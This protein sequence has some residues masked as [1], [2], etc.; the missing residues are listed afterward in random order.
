MA[1]SLPGLSGAMALYHIF[2]FLMIMLRRLLLRLSRR[3]CRAARSV[4][5]VPWGN[6]KAGGVFVS[7]LR[8]TGFRHLFSLPLFMQGVRL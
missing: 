7:R 6:D 4:S 2:R 5:P 1:D 8:V 3:L